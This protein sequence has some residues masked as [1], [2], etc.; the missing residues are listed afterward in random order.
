MVETMTASSE[1]TTSHLPFAVF[2]YVTGNLKFLGLQRENSTQRVLF[3]FEDA[4]NQAQ[5]IRLQYDNGA[6]CG[7]AA[8]HNALTYLRKQMDSVTSAQEHTSMEQITNET[9]T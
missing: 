8:Y 7:A 5:Q 6:V 2:L 9:R 1:F 3:Q 4:E